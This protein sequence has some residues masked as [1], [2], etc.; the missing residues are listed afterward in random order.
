[1]EKRLNILGFVEYLCNSTRCNSGHLPIFELNGVAT[2]LSFGGQLMY[3]RMVLACRNVVILG[4][5][6]IG[7]GH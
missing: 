1:M 7:V 2:K 6:H 3:S 5:A 4:K